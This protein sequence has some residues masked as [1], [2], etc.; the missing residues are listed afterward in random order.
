M[1]V[2][3][4]DTSALTGPNAQQ[5][6]HIFVTAD[7]FLLEPSESEGHIFVTISLPQMWEKGKRILQEDSE[8]FCLS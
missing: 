1:Y 6:E 8:G 7:C 5:A 4:E 2:T 3:F